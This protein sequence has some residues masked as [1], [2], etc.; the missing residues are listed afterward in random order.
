[1]KFLFS[2]YPFKKLNSGGFSFLNL[3]IKVFSKNNNYIN[4]WEQADLILLNSHHWINSVF[5]IILLKI[6]G[7]EFVLR[8]DGPLN[9]YRKTY[10]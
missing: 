10:H 5:K 7:R 8:I 9:I 4:N 1:M 3:L 2:V 6:K